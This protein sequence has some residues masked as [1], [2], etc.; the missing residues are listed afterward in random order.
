MRIL[1]FAY[2]CEPNRGS[3]PGAGWWWANMLT[4]IGETWV[5]TRTISRPIIE[6]ELESA[7][8]PA[9]IRFVYVDLPT[10]LQRWEQQERGVRLYYLAWQFLALRQAR[11][12]VRH[13]Q[14]DLVWHLTL[15]NAWIGSTASLLKA[16]FV[17]GPV[18]GGVGTPWRLARG[19]GVRGF[20]YEVARTL[21]RSVGRFLNPLARASWRRADLILAQNEETRQ[22]LPRDHQAK[23]AVFP[24][25]VLDGIPGTH[26]HDR[27]QV[28]LFAGRLIGWKGAS[29]AI[30]A[31]ERLPDWRLIVCGDG[32]DSG[33]LR[34]MAAR[35]GLEDRVEFRGWV[36][37]ADLLHTMRDEASVF[38]FP[39]FHDEAGWVVVEAMASGLP[40]VCLD[41]GGPPILVGGGT[42]VTAAGVR[43]TAEGIAQRVRVAAD[44]DPE[45]PR[46]RAQQ[47]LYEHRVARLQELLEQRMPLSPANGR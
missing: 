31:L 15:A 47:F 27:H 26:R 10:R 33:R 19:L 39:S 32:P 13:H 14:F 6:Q 41:L 4:N 45:D 3:E 46:T 1:A 17:Y 44:T 23:A 36:K 43:G 29:L 21:V 22:W 7:R 12:L 20:F 8:Q 2:A 34:R 38:V 30:R 11:R 9:N 16:P 25:V 24:N 40:V 5:I 37:R 35:G 18:G 28:L 42:I